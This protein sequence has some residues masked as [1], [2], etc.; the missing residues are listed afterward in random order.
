LINTPD[1]VELWVKDIDNLTYETS[2]KFHKNTVRTKYMYYAQNNTKASFII[3]QISKLTIQEN[4]YS[5]GTT[6]YIVYTC[7]YQTLELFLKKKET[8]KIK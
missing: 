6:K 2:D 5:I 1:Y 4:K 3:L 7:M 8:V